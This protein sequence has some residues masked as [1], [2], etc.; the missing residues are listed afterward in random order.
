[1]TAALEIRDDL[2]P[3]HLELGRYLEREGRRDD[4]IRHYRDALRHDPSS[5]AALEALQRL[6]AASTSPS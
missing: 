4:A 2:V 6:G 1:L 3:A 5:I